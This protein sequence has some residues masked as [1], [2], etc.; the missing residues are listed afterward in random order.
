MDRKRTL[1]RLAAYGLVITAGLHL[2]GHFAPAAPPANESEETLRRLLTSY[3]FNFAGIS[4][5]TMDFLRGFSLSFA[6]LALFVGILDLAIAR[7]ERTGR[8]FLQTVI[9]IN[10]LFVGVQLVIAAIYFIYPPI[11]SFAIVFLLLVGAFFAP[12]AEDLRA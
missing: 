12:A 4:R 8:A 10:L 3:R 11:I 5:S 9:L 2:V 7:Y 1:F 6:A